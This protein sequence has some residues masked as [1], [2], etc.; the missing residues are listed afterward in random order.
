MVEKDEFAYR[1][2]MVFYHHYH[3]IKPLVLNGA[4]I[5]KDINHHNISISKSKIASCNSTE[6]IKMIL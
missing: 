6:I 3:A 4:G 1:G 2:N 5:M